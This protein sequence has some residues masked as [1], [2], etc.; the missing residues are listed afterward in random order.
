MTANQENLVT[1]HMKHY[2]EQTSGWWL[3]WGVTGR[4]IVLAQVSGVKLISHT[5]TARYENNSKALSPAH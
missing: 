1:Q 3:T 2:A 4:M 5:S